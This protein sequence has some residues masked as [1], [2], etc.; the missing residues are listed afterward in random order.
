[1]RNRFPCQFTFTQ[2]TFLLIKLPLTGTC[3]LSDPVRTIAKKNVTSV[4]WLELCLFMC[5]VAVPL[6]ARSVTEISTTSNDQNWVDWLERTL[7]M[8]QQWIENS[9]LATGCLKD[10]EQQ[11]TGSEVLSLVSL[12]KHYIHIT[13]N[14]YHCHCSIDLEMSA[15]KHGNTFYTLSSSV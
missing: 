11:V 1:M 9:W 5:L 12:R 8:W 13:Y 14:R 10:M 2:F 15:S 6:V 7:L 3:Y 4:N